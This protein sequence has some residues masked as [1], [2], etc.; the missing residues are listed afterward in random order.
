M[1]LDKE[2]Q[3]RLLRYGYLT[4]IWALLQLNPNRFFRVEEISQRTGLRPS[5]VKQG[6]KFVKQ[7]PSIETRVTYEKG[8]RIVR[9]GF[10]PI[11][12]DLSKKYPKN[13]E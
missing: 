10:V 1:I 9:N 13:K 8:N 2:Q 7:L 4:R 12:P 11:E 6:L 3:E 5:T